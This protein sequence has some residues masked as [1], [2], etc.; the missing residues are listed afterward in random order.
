MKV[1]LYANERNEPASKRLQNVIETCLPSNCL[2]VF[3]NSRDFAQRIY[4]IPR[5]ID[6]AVLFAQNHDQLS[7]LI[8]FKGFPD[9]CPNYSHSAGQGAFDRHKRAYPVSKL[10]ELCRQQRHRC[11]FGIKQDDFEL[12][13]QEAVLSRD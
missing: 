3:G 13:R 1:V 12:G 9:G 8:I 5:K 10:Y 6:V 2:E 4:Q 11:C 7:E